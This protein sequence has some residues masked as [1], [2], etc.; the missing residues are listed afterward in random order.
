M[1]RPTTSRVRCRRVARAAAIGV[2]L[3]WFGLGWASA[4]AHL[5]IDPP[6]GELRLVVF[7]DFNGSYGAVTYPG[8]VTRVIDAT[9][10]VW[11]P[12]LVLLPGD[13]VAGQSHALPAGRFDEMWAAFDTVVAAPLRRAGVPY[14]ASLG[15]HDAS[16]LRDAT[17]GFAF[18]RER[19]AA[20]RYWDDPQHLAGLDVVERGSFP[21]AWSF[22]LGRTFVAIVDASGPVLDATERD[23]LA[24][25]LASSPAREAGLR[26][27]VGHL[28]LVGI[29]VGRDRDGEVLWEAPSLRDLLVAGG[30]DTYVSGHQAAFYAG[31]WD[32]FELLFSG[33][34]GARRLRGHDGPPRSAVTVADV[35]F[36]PRRVSLTSFDAATLEPLP[37]LPERLD[38]FGG[39]VHRS[40][41]VR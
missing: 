6:R 28:P 15:N 39:T 9:V 29:A 40:I 18:A 5:P 12:D 7:G 36:E 26:W 17:G 4:Q 25:V 20:T 35:W 24:R 31:T 13:V 23:A 19:A 14:A 32:G 27:V 16:K 21:F 38:G 10:D 22:R 2:T 41:R 11:R 1:Q 33:G 8:P 30:V 34:V 3:A 37:M